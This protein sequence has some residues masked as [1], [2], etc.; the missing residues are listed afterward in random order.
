MLMRTCL[1]LGT[2]L[3]ERG[4]DF[5]CQS[6]PHFLSINEGLRLH[7]LEDLTAPMFCGLPSGPG[8]LL[9]SCQALSAQWAS[10][11]IP[12]A[13]GPRKE[14]AGVRPVGTEE[15]L[16]VVVQ[17]FLGGWGLAL[18]C[19]VSLVTAVT[20]FLTGESFS[21]THCQDLQVLW[22]GRNKSPRGSQLLS[23]QVRIT[24]RE[25]QRSVGTA[26]STCLVLANSL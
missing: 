21:R 9:Q 11:S 15:I 19:V 1:C 14:Q 2:R 20:S 17:P 25:N 10:S 7:D 24:R 5:Q 12:H 13:P 3:P 6:R 23:T 4:G 18:P 22:R 16:G 26:A 8:R